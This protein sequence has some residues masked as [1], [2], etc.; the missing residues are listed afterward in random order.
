MAKLLFNAAILGK[1][2]HSL[3]NEIA[4][5]SRDQSALKSVYFRFN[6]DWQ[7]ICSFIS[8]CNAWLVLLLAAVI[9]KPNQIQVRFQAHIHTFIDV[10]NSF[11]WFW[12]FENY[13]NYLLSATELS[14]ELDTVI[15][16]V[17]AAPQFSVLNCAISFSESFEVWLHAK[18]E[19]WGR[20]GCIFRTKL[21]NHILQWGY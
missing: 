13:V 2:S 15:V 21:W 17:T 16:K 6:S 4:R 3:G 19:F 7:W 1:L 14:T 11:G 18:C 20:N 10:I 9:A 8:V 5:L 12:A